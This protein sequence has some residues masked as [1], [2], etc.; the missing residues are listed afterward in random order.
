MTTR[1][2]FRM[3]YEPCTGRCYAPSDVVRMDS[4]GADV[5][6]MAMLLD[7]L[8]KIHEPA[9]GN[10]HLGYGLD[11]CE[12]TG[13]YIATF[14]HY[15]ALEIFTSDKIFD[16]LVK[17]ADAAI[18]FYESDAGQNLLQTRPG[19]GHDV[20]EHGKEYDLRHFALRYSGLPAETR[21]QLLAR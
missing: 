21:A 4:F 20:C 17:L 9:C 7:K 5:E 11:L 19:L 15:G 1:K 2:L 14:Q 8:M 16:A 6:K 12:E 10:E 18:S 13:L 3:K